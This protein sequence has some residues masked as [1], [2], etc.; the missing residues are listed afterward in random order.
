[1]GLKEPP[2]DSEQQIQHAI[3]SERHRLGRLL[4]LPPGPGLF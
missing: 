2:A 3:S 4:S 1:M